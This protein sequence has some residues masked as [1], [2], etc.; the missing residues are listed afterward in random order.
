MRIILVLLLAPCLHC[1][2]PSSLILPSPSESA[3]KQ[4]RLQKTATARGLTVAQVQEADSAHTDENPPETL[5]ENPQLREKAALQW[6]SLCASCHGKRGRGQNVPKL[7]PAPRAFG[8]FGIAMGFLMGGNKMR[9]AIFRK[10]QD[11][12][13]N[14]PSFKEQLT[15]E[16][17]WGLV[18][19]IEHL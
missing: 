17:I 13:K 15:N 18:Y 10:I 7:S 11:G 1:A 16:E 6:A 9:G 2:A 3:A 14:M 5:W 4:E 19:F 12:T 8:G